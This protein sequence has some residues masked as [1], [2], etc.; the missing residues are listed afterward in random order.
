MFKSYLVDV[1]VLARAVL[2]SAAASSQV[3]LSALYGVTSAILPPLF[4]GS[5]AVVYDTISCEKQPVL[6]FINL[7]I[8]IV[9]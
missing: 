8:L 6:K 4:S 7:A 2:I 1:E 3:C 9:Y 5:Y